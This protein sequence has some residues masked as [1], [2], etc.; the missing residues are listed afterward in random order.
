MAVKV[1]ADESVLQEYAAIC[2]LRHPNI[3]KPIA[4]SVFCDPDTR[5]SSASSS[6]GT[7]TVSNIRD[8]NFVSMACYEFAVNGDLASYIK[9][10][11]ERRL[12]ITFLS[13][14]FN[15]ILCAMEHVGTFGYI[16]GDIK[17]E[18]VRCN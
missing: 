5:A 6:S 1:A 4:F 11:P 9:R 16:H 13:N 10:H 17:P 8:G 2:K 7:S 3:V 15:D 14:L 18:N 12:D